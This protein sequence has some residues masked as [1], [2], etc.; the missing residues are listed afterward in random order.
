LIKAICFDLDGVFFT[1]ESFNIFKDEIA[2]LTEFPDLIDGVFHG[3]E[4]NDFKLNK[5]T[6]NEYLNYVR[7]SL[8]ISLTNEEISE[9]LGN[10]YSIDHD[11]LDYILKIK[12][13][14][15]KTCLCSNNFVTRITALEKSFGFLKYFDIKIFSCDAEFLKPDIRIFQTLVEQS[16][17]DVSEIV[18]SD[19]DEIKLAGA[20]ELGINTFVFENFRQ[21]RYELE[22]LGVRILRD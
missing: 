1:K 8:K 7:N 14:G 16:R 11:V 5:L 18:Y 4:M 6:E 19:D 9:I 15:Y 2:E 3:P 13:S 20:K 17:V 10:S 22:L 12:D 21:F